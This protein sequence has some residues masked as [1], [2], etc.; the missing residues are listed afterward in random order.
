M[1]YQISFVHKIHILKV[2]KS[3]FIRCFQVMGR[4]CDCYGFGC[5]RV[6][7]C[8]GL[9]VCVC[10]CGHVCVCVCVYGVCVKN[11]LLSSN[12]RH[13]GGVFSP[14]IFRNLIYN[15]AVSGF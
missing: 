11:W 8:V 2:L 5:V 7:V 9:C 13:S 1:Y 6:C 15:S 3:P 4:E 12:I 14:K 10:E